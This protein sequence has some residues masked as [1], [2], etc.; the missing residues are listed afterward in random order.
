[1]FNQA[2]RKLNM[3]FRN[4]INVIKLYLGEFWLFVRKNKIGLILSIHTYF[5]ASSK[6]LWQVTLNCNSDTEKYFLEVQL[7]NTNGLDTFVFY[8][9]MIVFRCHL[10]QLIILSWIFSSFT[11]KKPICGMEGLRLKLEK[12]L[13][14]KN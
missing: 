6:K 8:R 7:S 2:C 14:K 13:S 5:D 3:F 9:S 11:K 4:M 1:M 10:R 12:N